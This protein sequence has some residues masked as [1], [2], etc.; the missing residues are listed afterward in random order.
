MLEGID[1]AKFLSAFVL[2]IFLIF[3]IYYLVSRYGKNI[4]SLNQKGEIKIKDIK[5]L[6]K[7][8]N[9]LFIEVK[10]KEFL[11]SVDE[12]E[13]KVIEKWNLTKDKESNEEN[14]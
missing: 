5:F 8:K 1:I 10:D 12:K 13:I 14:I 9:L 3:S 6:G 7:G 2:T 4:V 11:L